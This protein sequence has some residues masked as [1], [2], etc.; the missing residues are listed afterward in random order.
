MAGNRR[1]PPGIFVYGAN[2]SPLADWLCQYDA[3]RTITNEMY[4]AIIEHFETRAISIREV[5]NLLPH[6]RHSSIHIEATPH[7]PHQRP[8]YERVWGAWDK[9]VPTPS[10]RLLTR[11]FALKIPKHLLPDD[12]DSTY[13]PLLRPGV[14]V[15]STDLLTTAGVLVKNSQNESFITVASHGFPLEDTNVYHP[16]P[17][18]LLIGEVVRR[19]GSTGVALAKLHNNTRFRKPYFPKSA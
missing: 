11:H 13:V 7:T 19:I 2:D 16:D 18:S 17:E 3:K 9:N 15:S 8:S 6:R 12:S 14:M 10:N 1:R 5:I 4:L